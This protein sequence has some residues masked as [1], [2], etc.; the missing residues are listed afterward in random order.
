LFV[1]FPDLNR[2]DEKMNTLFFDKG[3][4]ERKERI[5]ALL[6]IVFFGWL[7]FQM[8]WFTG[9][10]G[11]PAALTAGQAIVTLADTDGDG[12]EN[13][14][15]DCPLLAGV[16]INRGCP[17]DRDGDGVADAKDACPGDI[18][19]AVDQG[20]PVSRSMDQKAEQL[21][22][23]NEFVAMKTDR[24]GDGIADSADRCPDVKGSAD[25]DGCPAHQS[26]RQAIAKMQ[27]GET[28]AESEPVAQKIDTDGDGFFD[29]VDQCP[30]IAGSANGCPVDTDADGVPDEQ[31][32]C[33]TI[34]GVTVNHGC[35]AD[36]DG[37]GVADNNDQCVDLPGV[38]ENAGCPVDSDGDQVYDADDNCPDRAGVLTN[39]GCPEVKVTQ[40][41]RRIIDEAI[42]SV[43]FIS[44][45]STLTVYSKKLLDKVA[46]LLIE[47]PQYKLRISGHTDSS[48]D[49]TFNLQLSR[50]RALTTFNYL[51]SKGVSK[52]RMSHDG[53][54]DT[55][56]I[57]S[58]DT[59]QGRLK[60]R[61]VDFELY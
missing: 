17:A 9:E 39:L 20:C 46:R 33:R 41:E 25:S 29:F 34:K 35:P 8:G 42:A 22:P 48:G 31:D 3:P 5:I 30:Q 12:V 28:L 36:T 27:A 40:A 60:N 19:F 50:N 1:L 44:G 24:D 58:N 10:T 15:D 55:Q 14:H 52:H 38:S 23:S 49:N 53:F 56:P 59:R 7:I 45:R 11:R 61:R 2:V 18:G 4:K 26:A 21:L 37:D 6:V 54:G 32:R 57:A 13:T 47:N 51:A 16:A 43:K